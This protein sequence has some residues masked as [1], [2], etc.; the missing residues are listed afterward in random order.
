MNGGRQPV[1]L[2]P[3]HGVARFD[4][5]DPALNDWLTKRALANQRSGASRTWVTLGADD[6]VVGYYASATAAVLRE[7]LSTKAARNQPDPVPAILLG[8]LAIDAKHQGQG[9]GPGLLKHFLLKAIEVAEVVG[10]RLVLVHAK[11]EAARGFYEHFGFE[12]TPF[13]EYT[14]MLLVRDLLPQFPD[15]PRLF[16][17][18]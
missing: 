15:E 5:G 10:V 7:R 3:E 1:L 17:L 4:C 9:I 13:D 11:D 18:P 8:R 12:P 2:R 14:L 16:Q 6:E